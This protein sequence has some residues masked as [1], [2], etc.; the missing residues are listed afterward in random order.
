MR[1]IVCFVKSAL[2]FQSSK[3]STLLK[4]RRLAG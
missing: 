4:P 1:L 3:I 2:V